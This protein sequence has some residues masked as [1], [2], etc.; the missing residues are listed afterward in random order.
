MVLHLVRGRFLPKPFEFIS[1][2]IIR[3]DMVSLLKVSLNNQCINNRWTAKLGL[4]E[5]TDGGCTLCNEAPYV[6]LGE[7]WVMGFYGLLC[8]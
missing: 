2:H 8:V 1:Y 6:V 5:D 7:R 4:S 3:R